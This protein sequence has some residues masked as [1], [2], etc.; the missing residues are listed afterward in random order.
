MLLF[1]KED[2]YFGQ[3]LTIDSVVNDY[4]DTEGIENE[5]RYIKRFLR[6]LSTILTDEQQ[7]QL[8][9]KLYYKVVETQ[10]EWS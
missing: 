4:L 9:N 6:H 2:C 5:I 8:A 10:D 7:I 3:N 1:E